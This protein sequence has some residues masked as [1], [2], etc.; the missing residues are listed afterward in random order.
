MSVA[1]DID[2]QLLDAL[3]REGLDTVD[4]VFACAGGE[5]LN[6]PGLGNRRR[7]RLSLTDQTGAA[8][9][10]YLKRYGPG[11]LSARLRRAVFGLASAG[12]RE[13]QN[14]RAVRAAGVATMSPLICGAD[15]TGRSYLVVTAVT[16]DALERCGQA[17]MDRCASGREGEL[18]DR[19]VELAR[20]LH[21]AGLVH[22]DF[23]SSHIFLD[24]STG[25][26]ALHLIDLARVFAPRWRRFRWCVKDLAQLKY[27]MP[28][29]W[30]ETCWEDFL[31]GYLKGAGGDKHRW[32]GRIDR[33][34]SAM[35]RRHQ[36]AGAK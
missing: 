27:S 25:R 16:G 35:R 33:K 4:G 13:F 32:A 8:H 11:P 15:A 30:V 17:F 31:T 14:I 21:G 3:R 24:E 1:E 23:Y 6:K 12:Q 5:D 26:P 18:T 9:E 34:V 29:R 7:T 19:L 28:P 2:P 36:R 22:R 20:S 10:V